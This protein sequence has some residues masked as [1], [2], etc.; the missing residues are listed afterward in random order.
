MKNLHNFPE[1]RGYGVNFINDSLINTKFAFDYFKNIV[2]YPNVSIEW[3]G[4]R[5]LYPRKID[6]Y[7]NL[8]YRCI[9]TVIKQTN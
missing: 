7:L 6:K 2:K 3:R 5:G 4:K 9:E 8:I 1:I